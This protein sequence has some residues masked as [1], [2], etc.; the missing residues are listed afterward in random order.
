VKRV[1]HLAI[2]AGEAACASSPGKFCEHVRTRRFGT[3]SVCGLFRD[4]RYANSATQLQDVDGWLQRLP[5]CIA[6]ERAGV[7]AGRGGR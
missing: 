3:E 1:L 7:P 2:E 5:E 6:A 4:R